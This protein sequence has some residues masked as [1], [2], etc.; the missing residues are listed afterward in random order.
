MKKMK[1][2]FHIFNIVTI[3]FYLFPCSIMGLI[4][5]GNCK[6]QPQLIKI[7]IIPTNH[8]IVFFLLSML[9]FISFRERKKKFIFFYLFLISIILEI[10]HKFIPTRAFELNDM[11]GNIMG[12]I[13]S[14]L[15]IKIINYWRSK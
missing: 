13:L 4:F 5:L 14:I 2:L 12:I 3:I 15:I 9:G 1:T 11:F 10:M 7:S 6:L 8:I